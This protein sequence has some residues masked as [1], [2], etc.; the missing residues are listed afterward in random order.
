LG[1]TG[2]ILLNPNIPGLAD[3]PD[4][5]D[6]AEYNELPDHPLRA[7]LSDLPNP[8]FRTVSE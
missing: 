1:T 2:L 4:I 3:M 7:K 5:P 6:R 8:P